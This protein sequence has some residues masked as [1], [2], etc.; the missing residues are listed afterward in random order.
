MTKIN[1]CKACQLYDTSQKPKQIV[2]RPLIL[3]STSFSFKEWAAD[4]FSLHS[5]DYI[6]LVLG[7]QNIYNKH[8]AQAD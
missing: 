4:L 1:G 2:S 7:W 6:V 8:F 3:K 5:E